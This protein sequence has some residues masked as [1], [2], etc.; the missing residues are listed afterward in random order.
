MQFQKNDTPDFSNAETR[1]E[2]VQSAH[3]SKTLMQK[4]LDVNQAEQ[5]LLDK[6]LR[7][8]KSFMNDLPSSDPQYS[9]LALQIQMDQLE[10]NELKVGETI[11]IQKLT[12]GPSRNKFP[13]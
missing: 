2:F 6:R 9:M 1:Q 8:M 12:K 7:M 3:D 4:E 13:I 5:I 10:I 11:L